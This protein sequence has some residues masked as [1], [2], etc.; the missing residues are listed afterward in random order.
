M[1]GKKSQTTMSSY[2]E[3][4][5]NK[6][7]Q[8]WIKAA[9]ALKI[10]REGLV[11]FVQDVLTCVHQAI[12][13]N[14]TAAMGLPV[15]THCKKCFTENLLKCPTRGIC[16][17]TNCRFHHMYRYRPCPNNICERVRDEI[18]RYH[19]FSGPSW[20]NTNAEQWCTSPWEMGKCFLPP[21]GY[22]TVS[23]IQDSD[24]NGVINVMINCEAFQNNF[25]FSISTQTNL[26]TEIRQIGRDIRHSSDQKVKDST[27]VDYLYKLKKLLEDQCDLVNRPEAQATVKQLT[28]LQ[29]DD[30]RVSVDNVNEMLKKGLQLRL[31][32]H[33]QENLADM[34]IS[35][36]LPEDGAKLSL[37]FVA[38][39]I[40]EK[41]HKD[42]GKTS[43]YGKQ[44]TRYK[45][46]FCTESIK[47]NIF[48]VGE[49]GSGKSTF[50]AECALDWSRQHLEHEDNDRGPNQNP[51]AFVN[52]EY[53]EN[54]EFLFH[55]K[56]RDSCDVCDLNEFIRDQI[57]AQVYQPKD[58]EGAYKL[59][60]SVLETSNC[61]I[62][63]DGLDEWTHPTGSHCRCP[64][65]EKGRL[66]F[67]NSAI[68]AKVLITSRPWRLSQFRVKDIKIDKYLEIKGVTNVEELVDKVVSVLNGETGTKRSKDFF[69]YVSQLRLPDL[70]QKPIIT[71]QLV[72]IWYEGFTDTSSVCGIYANMIDM[73]FGRCN[74]AEESL[75]QMDASHLPDCITSKENIMKRQTALTKLSRLAFITLFSQD[76]KSTVVF[77]DTLVRRELTEAEIHL[78]VNVGILSEKRSFSITRKSSHF[79][80][81]HKTFQEFLA[82]LNLCSNQD[83]FDNTLVPRY[84]SVDQ[85]PL[86]DI[87]QV[88]IFTC[89]MKPQ[90]GIQI[91]S[92][93]A[94]VVARNSYKTG[95]LSGYKYL[96]ARP[97]YDAIVSLQRLVVS[98][99]REAN[100]NKHS[101]I[102]LILTHF[103]LNKD[104][105]DAIPLQQL[106]KI[107]KCRVQSLGIWGC[108]D[109]VSV[110]ELQEVITSSSD[111]LR[112]LELWDRS[113]QY[114]LSMCKKLGHLDIIGDNVRQLEVDLSNIT[115]CELSSVSGSIEQCIFT[116]TKKESKLQH[117]VLTNVKNIKLIPE[118]LPR[119]AQ[120][121]YLCLA[122][123]DIR[124]IHFLLP[125]SLTSITLLHVTMT[126]GE[127]RKLVERVENIQHTVE[128][129]IWQCSVEPQSDLENTRQYV[130]DSK[131]LRL[132]KYEQN[133]DYINFQFYRPETE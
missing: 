11:G 80:F 115:T 43:N 67:R 13:N 79:S 38:P 103:R 86:D 3:L 45:D 105:D 91:S 14:L 72:S 102:P 84:S 19:R 101:N 29:T 97:D 116:G 77:E 89:G 56:L 133:K 129:R 122:D 126:A 107:N 34:P 94:R 113:G 65:D 117:L 54:F 20:K 50:S 12:N 71:M 130:E 60:Q 70:R 109:T 112:A 52:M 24:F 32:N 131:L 58:V 46:L 48:L 88:F 118:T 39:N 31:A 22:K 114:D 33:Y 76:C 104:D 42:R 5:E 120:L 128:C 59:A 2:R 96:V 87:A 37:F 8:N 51:N 28:H 18:I 47:A 73:L 75:I 98:G 10:T 111:S 95:P 123:T 93:I 27:L 16:S 81:I 99:Y 15:G 4:L 108:N 57:I 44:V 25:S 62:I 64:R 41:D 69:A 36:S 23:S 119:L 49:P 125:D 17:T 85:N 68:N 6:E 74:N 55:V 53:F 26:L 124:E 100:A 63:A 7:S 121:Q 83:A 9:L 127:M 132:D 78:S 30:F 35:P 106:V 90:L 1:L 61:L 40:V 92:L 110:K 21:D 82:A 66:P